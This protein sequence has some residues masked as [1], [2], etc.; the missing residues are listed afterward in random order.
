LQKLTVVSKEE[1]ARDQF[2]KRYAGEL[3]GEIKKAAKEQTKGK[4]AAYMKVVEQRKGCI[5]KVH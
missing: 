2:K 3:E 5:K 4:N 1:N